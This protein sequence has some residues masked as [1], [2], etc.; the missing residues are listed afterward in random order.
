MKPGMKMMLVSQQRERGNY[1]RY[2][3]QKEAPMSYAEYDRPE[4]KFRD[5]RGR[6]HYDNGRYAPKGGYDGGSRMM[7]DDEPSPRMGYENNIRYESNRERPSNVIGF[8]RHGESQKKGKQQMGHASGGE[9]FENTAKEWMKSLQNADGSRGPHWTM[10]QAKS[11][12]HQA[13]ADC[14]PAEFWA[15][16]NAL[17]SDYSQ[18]LKKF[19]IDRTDVYAHMAKAWL[20]DEDAVDDKAAAYFEYIVEH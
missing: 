5:R 9:S 19:G 10:E 18:V 16:L 20:E 11:L 12:M 13:G 1:P 8:A 6:E 17:Y 3:D 4:S 7:E 15:V 14:D 2:E